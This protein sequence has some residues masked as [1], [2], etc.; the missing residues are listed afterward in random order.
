MGGQILN[1]LANRNHIID[2]ALTLRNAGGAALVASAA[3]TA[4]Q[5]GQSVPVDTGGG[6][7]EG[8]LFIDV[9]TCATGATIG[10]WYILLQGARDSTFTTFVTLAYLE[11]GLGNGPGT[12]SHSTD[13]STGI[14][15]VPWTNDFKG[16]VWRWLRCYTRLGQSYLGSADGAASMEPSAGGIDYSAWLTV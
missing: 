8:K 7:T 1:A 12:T 2:N 14:Y 3:A 9:N 15:V 4:A 5:T 13:H 10:P 6:F 11:L 16:E